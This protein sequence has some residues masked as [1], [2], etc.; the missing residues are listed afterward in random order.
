MAR[1][2]VRLAVGDPWCTRQDLLLIGGGRAGAP[3]HQCSVA[4]RIGYRREDP[5]SVSYTHLRA[6]ETRS[7]L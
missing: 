6:H 1:T 4:L 7:N 3:V 2:A 5:L